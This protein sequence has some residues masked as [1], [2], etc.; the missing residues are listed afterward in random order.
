MENIAYRSSVTNACI[1]QRQVSVSLFEHTNNYWASCG[2][3]EYNL[4]TEPDGAFCVV[5]E[6]RSN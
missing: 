3:L 5:Y 2:M 4:L 1:F 6:V